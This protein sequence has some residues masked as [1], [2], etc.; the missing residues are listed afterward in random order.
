MFVFAIVLGG[1]LRFDGLG[2]KPFWIDEVLFVW[3]IKGGLPH[4]EFVPVILAKL[5]NLEGEFWVRFPFAMAGTLTIWSVYYIS[6]DKLI[7][8]FLALVVATFPLFVFW[9]RMARPY[10]F[11]GLFVALGWRLPWCYFVALFTT[12]AALIGVNLLKVKKLFWL[13]LALGTVALVSYVVRA[14]VVSGADFLNLH[15]LTSI[16]RVWYVPCLAVIL[17]LSQFVGTTT[18][19]R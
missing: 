7:G 6:R 15:F 14:D 4:Q 13:Y 10:V 5:F 16:G 11:A 17:Y 12:P 1:F 2:I 19:K 8:S 3:W 18:I 9:S